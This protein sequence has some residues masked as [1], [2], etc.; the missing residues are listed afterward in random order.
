MEYMGYHTMNGV[1]QHTPVILERLRQED[2]LEFEASLKYTAR[3]NLKRGKE[4]NLNGT[5]HMS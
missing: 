5:S 3:T 4:K 1:W 2:D